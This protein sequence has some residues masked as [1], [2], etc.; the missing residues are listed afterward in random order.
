MANIFNSKEVYKRIPKVS[1]KDNPL[2]KV[3]GMYVTGDYRPPYYIDS[4]LHIMEMNT[5]KPTIVDFTQVTK[6]TYDD[7]TS[8]LLALDCNWNL[9]FNRYT[10][11]TSSV[12]DDSTSSLLSLDCSELTLTKIP[13]P[14]IY[15]DVDAGSVSSLIN[16]NCSWDLLITRY[17]TQKYE[18]VPEQICVVTDQYTTK[19]SIENVDKGA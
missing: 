12:T 7:S 6:S 15:V 3:R 16:I 14:K 8:S 1:S 11:A 4:S 13:R 10:R 9:K 5:N 17:H 2:R 19:A 18:S